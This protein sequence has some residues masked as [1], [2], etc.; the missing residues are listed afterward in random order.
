ML[1]K[2]MEKDYKKA[3][4]EL[5]NCKR[6][7]FF[8]HNDPDGLCSFLL[9]YRT[10]KQGKGVIL[11]TSA[12]MGVQF[13]KHVNNYQPDKIF[14][15]DKPL[16]SQDFIDKVKQ[17]I[18]WIDHHPPVKRYNITYINPR[19]INPKI[20]L[21]CSYLC[22][23][24]SKEVS[25]NDLWIAMVGCIGDWVMPD[26]AQ[27]FMKKY[28]S[29]VN[30][31]TKNPGKILFETKLGKLVKIFSFILKG[32]TKQA[33]ACVKILTRIQD[34]YEILEGKTSRAKFILKHFNKIN[35]EYEKLL[36]KAKEKAKGN[37]LLYIYKGDK[38]SLNSD[39]SNELLH[40]F[41]EKI[42]VVGREK[43]NE[44][45]I[46]IR[47]SKHILPEIIKKALQGCD[48]YGGGHEHAVG[49]N[50][51]KRDF[52]KFFKNFKNLAKA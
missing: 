43:N 24:I 35:E 38:I 8:F 34:P 11:K 13:V 23:N 7:L 44:I 29:L 28:P 15:L 50:I 41:P 20:N 42:I 37:I 49:V 33:M 32:K 46:S 21:P 9:L 27:E 26:F 48:G 25:K 51:K 3:K 14:I 39:L 18:I 5:I 45:K 12:E 4:D 22:Y 1:D 36:E 19:L 52:K 6:P 31:K 17:K 30:I 40:L 10:I 2:E 47:S 16:V